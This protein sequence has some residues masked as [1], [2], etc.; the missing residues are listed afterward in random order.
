MKSLPVA[1]PFALSLIL[2]LLLS[3]CGGGQE[4]ER[5][6][7]R[8]PLALASVGANEVLDWAEYRYAETFPK[9][10]ASFELDYQG[11][12]YTVRAYPNG[13]HLGITQ[14]GGIYGLGPFTNGDLRGF[15]R[16]ADYTAQVQADSCFVYP[17]SC[18]NTNPSGALNECTM[19]SADALTLGNQFRLTY[20]IVST[21]P[22]PASGETLI[23]GQVTQ[24]VPFE[25][26][27]AVQIT[28]SAT[29]NTVS[30]GQSS[31]TTLQTKDYAQE[32]AN[33]LTL[34]MGSESDSDVRTAQGNLRT[35]SKLVYLPPYLNNEFTLQPGQ[36]LTRTV[37][38]RLT[39]SVSAG[40]VPLPSTQVDQSRTETLSYEARESLNVQ[41]RS[42]D[43]CRYRKTQAN[44]NEVTLSWYLVGKGIPV[45]TR[46]E[47]GQQ[48]ETTEL[49]SGT[50]NGQPL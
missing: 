43:T 32:A 35:V 34:V 4:P 14:D 18:P 29:I 5:S 48:V 47:S 19:R 40:G 13:N 49:K 50:Y 26:Q 3:A 16:V 22:N 46:V 7:Q 45:Q 20:Q 6:P 12:T 31:L 42:Y 10:P 15:G 28:S 23:E 9:G 44:S 39:S 36:S 8:R 11:V 38:S 33:G 17:A 37:G 41:G 25:G 21:G 27:S 30:N 1:R 24:H 2:S